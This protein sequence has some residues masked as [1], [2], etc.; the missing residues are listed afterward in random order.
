[1]STKLSKSDLLDWM[2]KNK[3]SITFDSPMRWQRKDSTMWSSDW[4]VTDNQ[5]AYPVYETVEETLQQAY[6]VW[7]QK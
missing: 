4:R 5:T 6:I 7:S 3:I 1:M 2:L